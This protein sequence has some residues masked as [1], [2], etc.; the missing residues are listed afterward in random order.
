MKHIIVTGSV[1]SGTSLLMRMLESCGIPVVTDGIKPPDQNNPYG[2][3][4]TRQVLA[5]R[6]GD[7]SVLNGAE[8]KALKV[9]PPTLLS[10][11]PDTYVYRT[12]FMQ[13]NPQEVASS[14]CKYFRSRNTAPNAFGWAKN[15]Q[16]F[17]Q[18]FLEKHIPRIDEA[19]KFVSSNIH[20]ETL[21]VDHNE[22]MTSPLVV[23]SQI[24]THLS[25]DFP[26][27]TF[28]PQAMAALV[29]PALYRQRLQ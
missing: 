8:G 12:I 29:D 21:F 24:S 1:R 13:R 23:T 11:M 16:E 20:F 26:Q 25:T 17:Q 2:Y 15:D 5:M 27:Y 10:R 22:L 19:A 9:L 3:Y 7:F 18:Q 6:K 28:D 14:F 4:E